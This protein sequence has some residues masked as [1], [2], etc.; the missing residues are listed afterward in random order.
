MIDRCT[1]V[2]GNRA[3]KRFLDLK[4][5]LYQIFSLTL[6]CFKPACWFNKNRTYGFIVEYYIFI[7]R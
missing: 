5:V 3:L 4:C 2:Y 6:C 1:L 7:Q